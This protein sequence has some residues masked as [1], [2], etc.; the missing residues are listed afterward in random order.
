MRAPLTRFARDDTGTTTIE[1]TIVALL[2][3]LMTFGLVEFG[4]ML[5]Q[6]NS[7]TKA[8]QLGARLAAVSDP[9]WTGLP[10][11]TDSGT[12]GGPWT[13]AY[14]VTCVGSGGGSCSTSG[15]D[16]T[17]MQ[18]LVYGR[19]ST[20]C[21]VIDVD[22]DPG[23]CDI[24]DRV[25]PANISVNYRNTGLG[26]AG[27]PG[28]PVPTITLRLTGLTFQFFALGDLLGLGPVTM[29]DFKVTMTGEDLSAA[30]P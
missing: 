14:N 8:V 12:P 21:G 27:R 28:G 4:Y 2:F 16:S 23:M 7:A 9:V 26:F 6:W 18:R 10:G 19:G 17:A 11:L 13:T 22:G 3:F 30:A 15:Y 1:F 29:P 24:F 5:F 20:T 25:T